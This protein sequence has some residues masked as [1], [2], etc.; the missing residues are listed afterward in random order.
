MA[1]NPFERTIERTTETIL[2]P[3]SK[4]ITA[5]ARVSLSFTSFYFVHDEKK[6]RHEDSVLWI[7][8]ANSRE[9]QSGHNPTGA[10][11]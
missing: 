11:G 8:L 5:A 2:N 6:T 10:N 1:C 3:S 7:Y 9:T 4:T